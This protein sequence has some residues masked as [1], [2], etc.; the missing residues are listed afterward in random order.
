VIAGWITEQFS[1]RW[2]F[3]GLAPF[4][5]LGGLMLVPSLRQLR[6]HTSHGALA[7]PRRIG[8]AVLAAAGI[9]AVANVGEH[10]S[11]VN[12][13]IA[14]LGAVAMV[15]GLRRL[16]PKGTASFRAGVP[17]AVAFR[18]V[19]AGIFFG[20]EAVVPLTLTVQHHYSPTLSGIPLMFTAVTWAIGSFVQGRLKNANRPL[21]VA[22]G[23][24]LIAAGGLGMALVGSDTVAGW[25]SFLAWPIAGLGAGFAL[26]S[27][28][29][30][31]LEFTNDADRGSDSSS[32]QLA[33][34]SMSALCTAF[35]GALVAAAANGRISYG[36]GFA[37][38]YLALAGVALLAISRARQLRCPTSAS[39][40]VA[41]VQ[42]SL[43]AP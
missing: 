16:L 32:L 2:V 22:I 10:Q 28:S 30:V 41:M 7:D 23:L 39:S 18:G 4:V 27:S 15:A 13:G 12:I 11:A 35:S 17:A 25:W 34:S 37:I 21:L 31:L 14:F 36:V 5:A 6:T 42:P 20:M 24:A 8:F 33:D 1:W 43:G 38:V 9:A 26:T 29:V 40:E 3:G 19:L